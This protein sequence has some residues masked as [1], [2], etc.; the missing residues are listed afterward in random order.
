MTT[1]IPNP[2][3]L[4]GAPGMVDGLRPQDLQWG[5]LVSELPRAAHT[6]ILIDGTPAN[7]VLVRWC[8]SESTEVA[9]I[10]PA[11]TIRLPFGKL[12]DQ[13]LPVGALRDLSAAGGYVGPLLPQAI[14][15]P[16]SNGEAHVF[17]RLRYSDQDA[18]FIR[19]T[20]A[21]F[22]WDGG[23][24]PAL[25]ESIARRNNEHQ[26]FL[27]NHQCYYER[28]FRGEEIEHKYTLSGGDIWT[29]TVEL[30]NE[31]RT[32]FLQG[33]V[34]EYRDEFQTWDYGNHLHA[35]EEPE[36][37]RGY[38]SFIPLV[39]GGYT[40]KRK[41]FAEDAFRR[42]ERMSRETE[43]I[44]DFLAYIR[45]STGLSAR[46]LPSFRRVRYDINFES[47]RTGHVYGI[48]FDECTIEDAPE[49]RL[50]QCELEYLRTRSVLRRDE[51]E[52]VSEM[53]EVALW[54]ESF[55]DQKGFSS[56][57]GTYS[58]LSFLRDAVSSDGRLLE[59]YV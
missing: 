52:I 1:T 48:F 12:F 17:T 51:G 10:G 3:L 13:M 26:L 15:M 28:Y 42:G 8:V 5:V 27:N 50:M 40:V 14:V 58:K 16:V 56:K 43:Y 11:G 25:I 6:E 20:D 35:I 59:R 34:P 33:F 53:E 55:L 45:E 2:L 7:T 30:Y 39:G 23:V 18:I 24:S 54:L 9:V 44:P 22:P 46:A 57:R 32:G 19:V 49:H 21:P 41:W 37:E 31:V 38:I 29:A 4:I 36:S 47:I